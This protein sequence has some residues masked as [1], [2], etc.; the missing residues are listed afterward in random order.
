MNQKEK[1][2][3]FDYDAYVN[4]N[5]KNSN[6]K[7]KKNKHVHTHDKPFTQKNNAN[8][9]NVQKPVQV[10]EQLVQEIKTESEMKKQNDAV[11]AVKSDESV[12][13]AD[14][15]QQTKQVKSEQPVI[16]KEH[17]IFDAVKID[18]LQDAII[19]QP[20]QQVD[21]TAETDI[22]PIIKQTQ[23]IKVT[24][25]VEKEIEKP[26][27]K[28][29]DE[30]VVKSEEKE[31]ELAQENLLEKPVEK[32]L[33]KVIEKEKIVETKT[34]DEPAKS[35][36]VPEAKPVKSEPEKV[37]VADKKVKVSEDKT[38]EKEVDKSKNTD[39]SIKNKPQKDNKK[40][41]SEVKE[42]SKTDE[43]KTD[44]NK[45]DKSEN[46]KDKKDNKPKEDN[47]FTK[48][49][50]KNKGKKDT[51]ADKTEE[52]PTATEVVKSEDTQIDKE[53]KADDKSTEKATEDKKTEGLTK[54]EQVP[55]IRKKPKEETKREKRPI[56]KDKPK[57][58]HIKDE[59][60][61]P[62]DSI[63]KI[64]DEALDEDIQDIS[65]PEE[66]VDNV[67]P[68]DKEGSKR[69]INFVVGVLF[70]VFAVIGIISSVIFC[71]NAVNS[72][73]ENAKQKEEFAEFIY[74]V[75]ICDPPTFDETMK[76]RSDTMTTAA[77]WDIIINEDKSK[78]TAEFDY[79]IVPEVDVEKHATKLFGAG[80]KF[81]HKS[82]LNSD[83]QFFYEPDI[84]SYRIPIS[85]KYFTYS[86]VIENIDKAGNIYVLKVGY[87]SPAPD[88]SLINQEGER[89][90]DKYAEYVIKEVNGV[91]YLASIKQIDEVN[92]D[93]N[94][95]L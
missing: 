93:S 69:Q 3:I 61:E 79:I 84:K 8:A 87:L 31:P 29:I 77:I 34:S 10:K 23:D 20:E 71:V 37:I 82:I 27:E 65:V 24:K 22:K 91:K 59:K 48:F 76:L 68:E 41:N 7:K 80:L 62:L 92:N 72:F 86:P 70:S 1:N 51:P 30:V 2:E 66:N 25:A 32:V 85:P 4:E 49:L 54:I 89:I 43:E 58:E 15:S 64:I 11:N 60:A 88:W 67:V 14:N 13:P 33:S 21:I 52:K 90:P 44:T 53:E 78:Y 57:P 95:G 16:K 55:L 6:A 5:N 9:T 73:A 35:T 17:I 36:K 94:N 46:K 19:N 75:V 40:L 50:K 12:K 45:L 74:P 26:A 38:V 28:Q 56:S 81:D 63:K 83:V 18:K 42:I 39:K 47:F